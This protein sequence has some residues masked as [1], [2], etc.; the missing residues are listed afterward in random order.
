M[1]SIQKPI[2]P[3]GNAY[4]PG[5]IFNLCVSKIRD[6]LLRNKLIAVSPE[7]SSAGIEYERQAVTRSFNLIPRVNSLGGGTVSNDELKQVYE[8]RM[9]PKASPGRVVYDR[10]MRLGKKGSRKCPLCG[11]GLCKTLDHYLPQS[12]YSDL[13]VNPN[14]LVPCCRDCQSAKANH[15]PINP[16]KQTFH[17]YYDNFQSARWLYAEVQATAPASI[18]FI[19]R[20]PHDPVNFPYPMISRVRTHMKELGLYS[21]YTD[22]ACELSQDMRDTLSDLLNEGTPRD[23]RSHLEESA[24]KARRRAT[25]HWNTASLEAMASSRWY[26]AGGFNELE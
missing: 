7:I 15:F 9:V 6:D 18:T 23:V 13:V 25:N 21:V 3:M 2:D 14:N 22:Y 26:C 10:I 19:I 17:P 24:T 4:D 11:I 8:E 12:E 1:R 16:L 5:T 20:N